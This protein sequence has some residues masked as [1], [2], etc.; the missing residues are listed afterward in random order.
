[1][2]R[3][4]NL[5]LPIMCMILENNYFYHS[6]PKFNDTNVDYSANLIGKIQAGKPSP[7]KGKKKLSR[8]QRKNKL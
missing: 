4:L 2:S 3:I 5:A 1:M 7:H 8:K 6:N